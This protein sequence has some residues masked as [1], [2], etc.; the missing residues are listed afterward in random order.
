MRTTGPA[1]L[2]LNHST[3]VKIRSYQILIL[4]YSPFY[5]PDKTYTNASER[6]YDFIFASMISWHARTQYMAQDM[7]T[8]LKLVSPAFRVQRIVAMK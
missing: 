8:R 3:L 7:S 4:Q 6:L 1:H 5:I 2:N